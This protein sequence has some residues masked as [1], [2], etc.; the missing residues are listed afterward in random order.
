MWM[1]VSRLTA[2]FSWSLCLVFL[3]NVYFNDYSFIISLVIQWDD[4]PPYGLDYSWDFA[5]S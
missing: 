3:Q 2:L 5:L 4:S 1:F